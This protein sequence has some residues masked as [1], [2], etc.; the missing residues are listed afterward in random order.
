MLTRTAKR[1]QNQNS[2]RAGR[3]RKPS[4]FRKPDWIASAKFMSAPL[5]SVPRLN[6]SLIPQPFID[7]GLAP[8]LLV[9]A[10]DDDGAIKAR[11]VVLAGQGAGHHHRIG[12]HFAL[13]H[14]PAFAIDDLG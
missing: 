3:P 5:L 10:L 1:T 7:A 2:D 12:R 11:R 8:R 14:L 9:Y 13:Q 4:E 6:F